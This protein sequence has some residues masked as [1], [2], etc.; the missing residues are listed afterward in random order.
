MLSNNSDQSDLLIFLS[1]NGTAQTFRHRLPR[2]RP[3]PVAEQGAGAGQAEDTGE[4]DA[5][6]DPDPEVRPFGERDQPGD[7]IDYMAIRLVQRLFGNP[8]GHG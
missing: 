8:A 2:R 5:G 4:D 1:K 3:R 7:G 6:A